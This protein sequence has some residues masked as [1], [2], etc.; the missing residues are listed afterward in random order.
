MK[1]LA[2]KFLDRDAWSMNRGCCKPQVMASS[3][4]L[5]EPASPHF[6]VSTI[7]PVVLLGFWVGPDIED[8]WGFVETLANKIF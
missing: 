6:T 3:L 2:P 5:C 7:T 4:H 1:L 8:G